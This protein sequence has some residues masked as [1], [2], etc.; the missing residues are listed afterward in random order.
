MVYIFWPFLSPTLP[1]SVSNM[2]EEIPA[3]IQAKTDVPG[4]QI[5]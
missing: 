2:N 3:G 5:L 1:R 4:E